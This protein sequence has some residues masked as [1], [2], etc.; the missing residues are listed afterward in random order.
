MTCFETCAVDTVCSVGTRQ[1]AVDNN[2]FTIQPNLATEYTTIHFAN[3]AVMEQK[4]IR[5]FNAFGQIVS[6]VVTEN[7]N[8]YRMDLSNLAAG[9]YFINV[10]GE[11]TMAT[12]RLVI[13]Q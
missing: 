11:N 5:M 6:S 10:Q 12:K 13:Q 4:T 3:N 9:M 7:T 1:L 8:V 2:L